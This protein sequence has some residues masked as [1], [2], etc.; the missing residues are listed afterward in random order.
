MEKNLPKKNK[1]NSKGALRFLHS[2]LKGHIPA[3][4][5]ICVLM[6]A[7]A[8]VSVLMSLIMGKIIDAAAGGD[9]RLTFIYLGVM[10]GEVILLLVMR[11]TAQYLQS[12]MAFRMDM[13]LRSSLLK[14]IMT[15]EFAVISG[16]HSGDLMNR[17]TSDTYVISS[18]AASM[19]PNIFQMI[20]RLGFAFG[21]LSSFDWIFAVAAVAAAIVVAVVSVI[22]RPIIKRMHRRMQEAEGNTRSFMQETIDNQLVVRV[23]DRDGRVE[24]K[25]DKLQNITFRAY[26]KRRIASIFVGQG[27]HFMFNLGTMLA[28]CW[29]ALGLAGVLGDGRIVSFGTITAVIHLVGQ[30]Q[31]P[32]AG[33]TGVIPQFFTMTASCER[34]MEI[35][36]LPEETRFD[37]G[38]TPNEFRSARVEGI[39]FSYRKGDAKVRVFENASCA[40]EKGDFIAITGISGIGKSTFMKLLLGVYEPDGGSVTIDTDLG[41]I[42]ANVTC[43]GLF[44]YVPQ[45]NMLLSGTVRENIAFWADG[46]TD[47]EI[48]RAARIACADGFIKELPEG[49]D[50]TIGEH[51]H[52]ISEGQAQRLAV[53]RALLLKAP[54]LLLDE[55]TSALDAETE[56]KLLE[57]LR[58]SDVGT[59][60]I[61][62]HKTAALEVC[63]KEIRIDGGNISVREIKRG[64]GE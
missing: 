23:F 27:I 32:F 42:P 26:M 21:L 9:M 50:T 11:F 52:G 29:G 38:G 39:S 54:V 24:K 49:L 28:L 55:A 12:R 48:E 33:L 62:T 60:I 46:A 64:N 63:S 61:I 36:A 16:Y 25:T 6:A 58:S 41:P 2:R 44:A 34:L 3:L 45:G 59:V 40:V 35:E 7:T 8:I 10:L 19:L 57:N 20:A 51:G 15:R 31:A 17:M 56:K 53:A 22:F 47:E 43:R 18:T 14:K 13:T 37:A 30:V 5:L 4:V 1:V